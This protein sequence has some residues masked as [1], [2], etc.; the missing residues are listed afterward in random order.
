MLSSLSLLLLGSQSVLRNN[1]NKHCANTG[2]SLDRIL[3]TNVI[4][5]NDLNLGQ[6]PL[7]EFFK[8]YTHLTEEQTRGA[9]LGKPGDILQ[10][11]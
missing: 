11:L 5:L 2:A 4:E 7:S 6:I 8:I 10:W 9:G 3:A 1:Y